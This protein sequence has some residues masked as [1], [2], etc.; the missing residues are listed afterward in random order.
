[1]LAVASALSLTEPAATQTVRP[2]APGTPQPST[3]ASGERPDFATLRQDEDWPFLDASDSTTD[4]YDPL[5]RIRLNDDVVLTLAIDARLQHETFSDAVF[6]R[7]A[8]T[9]GSLHLRVIPHAS[10]A[11]GDRVRV[12]GA[13]K[14]GEVEGRR[15]AP[16]AVNDADPDLHQAFVEVAGGDA[17]GLDRG[18]L[19]LRVGRQELHYGSGRM[20]SI[21]EGPNLRLDFN[22]AIV[23]LRAGGTIA[24]AFAARPS[25]DDR[26]AFDNGLDET[27]ALWGLYSSTQVSDSVSLDL[28]Y[29]GLRREVSPYAFTPDPIDERRHSIGARL[30]AAPGE[31]GW[32]GDVEVIAQFGVLDSTA[33]KEGRIR[34]WSLA[35]NI[36]HAWPGAP[37]APVARLQL[38]ISSGDGD[39]S[40]RRL[41]TFRAPYP[42]GRYFGEGNPLGPGNLMG[43]RPEVDLT[44]TKKLTVT[45]EAGVFWRVRT[46]DGT[47][48]P[49]QMPVRGTSGDERFV[50]W[51]LGITAL[52]QLSSYYTIYGRA[53]RVTVGDYVRDNPPAENITYVEVGTSWRF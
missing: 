20:I 36:A 8:G 18:D 14:F 15:F 47:Y 52:Y 29:I 27:Q 43:L 4:P 38:G 53:A 37:L 12:Y 7:E 28:Y 32:S 9:D 24:E 22:G 13:L 25:E 21:R 34:A 26:G 2:R 39:A 16:L 49:P 35:G 51:Q 10:L 31:A 11:I 42:P 23:R 17:I 46:S 5:K 19:L 33:I 6:G 45:P 41:E 3:T 40:D 30:W 1:M 50:A 48:S 44:L